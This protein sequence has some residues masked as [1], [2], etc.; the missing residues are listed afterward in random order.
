MRPEDRYRKESVVEGYEKK[1][2]ESAGGRLVGEREIEIVGSMVNGGK[3]CLDLGCGK[4]RAT[5]VL[6]KMFKK[7][8][9]IDTSLPMIRSARERVSAKFL[10]GSCLNIPIKDESA[11][12]VV[13][14]RLLFHFE[15]REIRTILR[16]IF[17]VLRRDGELFFD[18]NNL[19]GIGILHM[20]YDWTKAILKR[21]YRLTFM[22]P[23]DIK[24]MLEDT[25]FRV[26]EE[27]K[28]FVIS[29]GILRLSGSAGKALFRLNLCLERLFPSLST[30]SYWRA[31]KYEE[32]EKKR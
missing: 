18:S 14:L 15:E 9:G 1:R 5:M 4:G 3:A 25:G 6:V 21:T 24:K 20:L 28:G 16:E 2:F 8:I 26:V 31:K 12:S 13:A 10:N 23:E 29:C 30:I 11:D 27:R 22:K 32:A 17:R 19:C 7:V